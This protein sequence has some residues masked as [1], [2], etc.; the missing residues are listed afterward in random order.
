MGR[1][2]CRDGEAMSDYAVSL[3]DLH[4]LMQ[5]MPVA[6]LLFN[7]VVTPQSEQVNVDGKRFDGVAVTL[8]CEEER[9]EAIVA[10]LRERLNSQGM[11]LYKKAG[12]Q[13]KRV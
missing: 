7:G 3:C 9:A 8:D 2:N 4:V 5:Q 6:A 10:V 13:W 1:C 12:A 11:R